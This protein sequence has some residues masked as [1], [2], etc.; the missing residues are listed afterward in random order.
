LATANSASY[1]NVQVYEGT[2]KPV[3]LKYT[4]KFYLKNFYSNAMNNLSFTSPVQVTGNFF[5]SYDISKLNAGDSLVVYMANRKADVTNSF[6]L[7]N[8]VDWSTYNSQNIEGNGSALLVELLACNIGDT[9]NIDTLKSNVTEARFF[10]NPISGNSTLYVETVDSIDSP[11]LI[12]VYDLLGKKQNI[13]FTQTSRY[14][15]GLNFAGK[16]AGIYFIHLESGGKS[17]V[18]KVTYLP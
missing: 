11:E 3:K 2:D 18:G 17:L 8:N 12:E 5:V 16:R 7:K 15:V 1:I 9:T 10:P 6:Y 4:E 13:P 14:K